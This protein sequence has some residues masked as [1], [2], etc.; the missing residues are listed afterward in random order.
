M[1]LFATPASPYSRKIRVLLLEKNVPHEVEMVELWEPNAL[2]AVNPLG[3]V[4]ALALADGRVLVSSPLIA[5]YVDGHFEGPRFLPEDPE[6]RLEVRRWEALADGAMDAV[7]AGLYEKRFHDEARRSAEWLARQHGKATAG[8]AALERMM[9]DREWCVGDCMSIADI[10]VAC[11]VGFVML[12]APELF[13][14]NLHSRITALW[15]RMEARP[16]LRATAPAR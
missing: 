8:F 6:V 15:R 2:A 9:Q 12:R 7:I 3:K 11:H 16:S 1:R 14:E 5:E 4:P 10:A 13:H